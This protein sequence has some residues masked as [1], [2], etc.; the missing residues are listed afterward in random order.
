[1]LIRSITHC[2]N[3]LLI[4]TT[5]LIPFKDKNLVTLNIRYFRRRSKSRPLSLSCEKYAEVFFK[6]NDFHPIYDTRHAYS[7]GNNRFISKGCLVW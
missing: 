1:M 4:T 3:Q 7:Y 2:A 5:I 6:L